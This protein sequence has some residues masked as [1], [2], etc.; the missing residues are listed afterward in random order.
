M[1]RQ[2]RAAIGQQT[3][4]IRDQVNRAGALT[5]AD[6]HALQANSLMLIAEAL[7]QVAEAIEEAG[8]R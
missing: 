5:P 1:G 4:N 3:N 2:E 8:R 7:L 6:G